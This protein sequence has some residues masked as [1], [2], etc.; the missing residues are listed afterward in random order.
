[1]HE[2]VLVCVCMHTKVV[3]I[4]VERQAKEMINCLMHLQCV[5][6]KII[7]SHPHDKTTVMMVVVVGGE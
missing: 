7:G 4:C 1:M 2:N 3:Q 5:M 6:K